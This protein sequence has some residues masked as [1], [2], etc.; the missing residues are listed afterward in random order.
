ME[1]GVQSNTISYQRL[2]VCIDS[3]WDSVEAAQSGALAFDG[4]TA[5]PYSC[6]SHAKPPRY[7]WINK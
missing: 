5:L 6:M 4:A 2:K 7:S 3:M 1:D